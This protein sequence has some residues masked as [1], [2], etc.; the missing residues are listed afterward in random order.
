MYKYGGVYSDLDTI[1]IK[2]F[3][4]LLDEGKNGFGNL[5]EKIGIG[6]LLFKS[7]TPYLEYV[8][9]KFPKIYKPDEW[10]TNG[11]ILLYESIKEFCKI[12]NIH[13]HLLQ[14]CFKK[15][16]KKINFTQ[17]PVYLNNTH[18]CADLRVFFQNFFYPFLWQNKDYKKIFEKNSKDND[19]L[20]RAV[21]NSYSIH[22]YGKLSSFNE[23]KPG[24]NSFFSFIAKKYC[25]VTYNYVQEHNLSFNGVH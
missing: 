4:P 24:D 2:S 18:K 20:K 14:G 5:D 19:D 9:N 25:S 16:P 8:I 22:Y 3:E 10:A 13:Y 15:M 23:A 12:D 7:K 21:S 6:V 1:T 17:T 11:P